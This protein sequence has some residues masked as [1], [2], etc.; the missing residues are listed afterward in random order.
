MGSVHDYSG[1]CSN[2]YPILQA[3]F[4]RIE[5]D[6]SLKYHFAGDESAFKKTKLYLRSTWRPPMPG[7]LAL[8]STPV[9]Q[10]LKNASCQCSER[11]KV[12]VI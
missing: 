12:E 6:V 7:T 10:R 11:R 9:Y 3:A 4:A 2:Y 8:T 5:R 1:S